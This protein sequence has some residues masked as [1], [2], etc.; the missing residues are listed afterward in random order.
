VR[1]E[2]A[3]RALQ[4]GDPDRWTLGWGEWEEIAATVLGAETEAP[5]APEDVSV[6]ETALEA[7][8]EA[9]WTR[10][11]SLAERKSGATWAAQTDKV[12]AAWRVGAE[13]SVSAYLAALQSKDVDA[14]TRA[15]RAIME[16]EGW[17]GFNAETVALMWETA[18]RDA[19][20]ALAGAGLQV[21]MPK[22]SELA[23][24]AFQRTAEDFLRAATPPSDDEDG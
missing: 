23:H 20:A 14:V 10:C 3:V 8:A 7:A 1:L 5:P 16:V 24:R 21:D 22:I 12:R 17:L 2:A 11:R 15:A 19:R 4:D 6:D 13:N 18:K 9:E